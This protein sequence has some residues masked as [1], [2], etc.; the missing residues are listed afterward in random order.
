LNDFVYRDGVLFCEDLRVSDIAEKVGTPFYL[1]SKNT[2][3]SHFQAVDQAFAE[4]PHIICYSVKTNSNLA[5]LNMMAKEGAG[6]DVVSGGEIYRARTAGIEANKI[7]FAGVGKTAAEIEYALRE[8][9]LLFNVESSQELMLINEIAAR[10]N[11]RAPIALRVNPDIDPQTHKYVATGLKES[12]FG[13][14][15]NQAMAEYEVA[16]KLPGLNP[17]GIH[18]H[19]GSQILSSAPF[20]NSVKKIANLAR[21]LRTLGMDIRRGGAFTGAVR[22]R[23]SAPP[24]RH[25]LRPDPRAG[26][27]DRRQR[28]YP[29]YFRALQQAGRGKEVRGGGRRHERP[30]AAEPV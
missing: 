10:N 6:A 17:I 7:V 12:K 29:G 8:G 11:V 19:I 28:R 21:S 5:I 18:Q 24:Q 4:V 30:S 2:L 22:R 23:G 13:I 14:P 1:Y 9:I 20:Q 25:R 16:Q 27:H 26:A 15:L 3:A